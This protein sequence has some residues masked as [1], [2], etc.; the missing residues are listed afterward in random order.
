MSTIP[1]YTLLA[2]IRQLLHRSFV[3]INVCFA[4]SE[5][6]ISHWNQATFSTS[7]CCKGWLLLTLVW[8]QEQI[9]KNMTELMKLL[10]MVAAMASWFKK[11]ATWGK[12]LWKKVLISVFRATKQSKPKHMKTT[13]NQPAFNNWEGCGFA[14]SKNSILVPKTWFQKHGLKIILRTIN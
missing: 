2:Y 5:K 8:T 12:G 1:M 7:S 14:H 10:E 11:V 4:S 13:C 3:W 9:W 6:V